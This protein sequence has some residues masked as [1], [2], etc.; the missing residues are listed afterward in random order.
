MCVCVCARVYECVCAGQCTH[1]PESSVGK[2]TAHSSCV[3]V[4]WLDLFICIHLHAVKRSCCW[5]LPEPTVFLDPGPILSAWLHGTVKRGA[6][7]SRPGRSASVRASGRRLS[8]DRHQLTPT[9][10]KCHWVRAWKIGTCMLIYRN[11]EKFWALLNQIT[12]PK[13]LTKSPFLWITVVCF[14]HIWRII[15]IR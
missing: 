11:A 1:H 12:E 9:T 13:L 2:G 10:S 5:Q 14:H 3:Q 15:N 7:G 6:A 8:A 4:S